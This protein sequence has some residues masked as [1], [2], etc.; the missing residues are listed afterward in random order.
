MKDEKPSWGPKY[1]NLASRA[2]ALGWNGKGSFWGL[3]S[4]V[5]LPK[6]FTDKYVCAGP[7][8]AQ[9]LVITG[10]AIEKRLEICEH[11][12]HQGR[13]QR[14]VIRPAL[15][16]LRYWLARLPRGDRHADSV[17]ADAGRGEGMISAHENGPKINASRI[18]EI[19]KAYGP[20]SKN[21][22]M[23][24][25]ARPELVEHLLL[26][27]RTID[28][29]LTPNATVTLK[30]WQVL[31]MAGF[32]LTIVA[33]QSIIDGVVRARELDAKWR[34]SPILFIWFPYNLISRQT[35][36]PDRN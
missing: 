11:V 6:D 26:A 20:L 19:E 1:P 27:R 5:G 23:L 2:L 32:E 30:E 4:F 15:R 3:C 8:R 13:N 14:G 25:D 18:T 9:N 31:A 10:D 16:R 21:Q 7:E 29:V 33:E 35:V 36:I 12:W 17:A 22:Q 24:L 28:E 34:K